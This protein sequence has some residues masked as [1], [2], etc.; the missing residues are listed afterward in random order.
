MRS[1]RHE[2]SQKHIDNIASF[3]SFASSTMINYASQAYRRAK[4]EHNDKVKKNIKIL[5][6]IIDQCFPTRGPWTP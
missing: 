5:N 2:N 3:D 1:V 4:D 6:V